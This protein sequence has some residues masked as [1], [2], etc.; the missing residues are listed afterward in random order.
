MP[1]DSSYLLARSERRPLSTDIQS[2][3][4]IEC[5]EF[6]DLSPNL[7]VRRSVWPPRGNC[8]HRALT[9][10]V[11]R[12]QLWKLGS[13][14]WEKP[15]FVGR[16]TLMMKQNWY[17]VSA[18]LVL[19]VRVEPCWTR[20][21]HQVQPTWMQLISSAITGQQQTANVYRLPC[22]TE[23]G[24]RKEVPRSAWKSWLYFWPRILH[25][26]VHWQKIIHQLTK[27]Q[28]YA[29]NDCCLA[30]QFPTQKFVWYC[31]WWI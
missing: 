7:L 23:R 1:H 5:S 14:L 19:L 29:S 15:A 17:K 25:K 31:E 11:I 13:I 26:D 9:V 16:A 10:L 27:F 8:T 22:S 12:Q 28:D 21:R 18:R 4:H 30:S 3:H 20:K 2:V 6:V 24:P